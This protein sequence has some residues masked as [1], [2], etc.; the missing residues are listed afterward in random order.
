MT[1]NEAV[2]HFRW[3]ATHDYSK[4]DSV[5]GKLVAIY[6]LGLWAGDLVDLLAMV[7]NLKATGLRRV[8]HDNGTWLRVDIVE[9]A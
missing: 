7:P 1:L 2:R 5:N 6:D 4:H 9:D 8:Q 3:S